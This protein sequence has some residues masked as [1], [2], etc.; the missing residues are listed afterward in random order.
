M[1]GTRRRATAV[2]VEVRGTVATCPHDL[3]GT[4]PAVRGFQ[5]QS[6]I[7]SAN[8]L[9]NSFCTVLELVKNPVGTYAVVKLFKLTLLICTREHVRY[10]IISD[11]V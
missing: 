10:M 5:V 9:Y 3:V 11:S 8:Q 4:I 6:D 7:L 2:K 1:T